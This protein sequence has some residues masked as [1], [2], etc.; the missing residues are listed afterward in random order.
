MLQ[1][2][3]EEITERSI[4]RVLILLGAPLVI[5]NLIHVANILVDTFWLGRVG[6][7]AVAAV[8]LA[9]PV[10]SI[11]AAGI[12]LVAVGTQITL[13]QRVGADEF[14]QARRLAFTG[15]ITAFVVGSVIS[16]IFAFGSDSLM[17]VLGGNGN[18]G[19]LAALYLWS[20]MLFYPIAF[21]SDTLENAFIGWGDTTA[22]LY[23]NLGIVGTN[24]I[25]DPFLILG[26]GPF[27]SFGVQGAAL[28]TG[29][30]IVVG[31]TLAIGFALGLRTTFTLD[32]ASATVEPAYVR[33]ILRVGTP[34]GGQRAVRD[35]VRVFIVGLVAIAGGTAGI[36]AFTVGTRVA[37]LAV[38]PALGFQQ[39]AQAMIS[40][41]IG[42]GRPD[43]ALKATLTGVGLVTVGLGLLGLAQW[44]IPGL[45]V[46]VLV[47]DVTPAGRALS[48]RFLRILA[49]SYWAMGATYLFLAAFNGA[50][51]TRTSFVVD[52]LKYWGVR[53]PIAL[54]AI[55]TTTTFAVFGIGFSPGLGLGIEAIFWAQAISIIVAGIGVTVY[56]AHTTQRGM[57]QRAATQAAQTIG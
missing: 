46:D 49:I 9:F 15:V 23:I 19:E 3:P 18:A 12:A 37:T 5:Q 33:E 42:A 43:R 54:A 30:G 28:A 21:A 38:V 4:P 29:A 44:L 41:N 7:T 24:V 13:A 48:I 35:I 31:F 25:L 45:I 40:Q 10:I 39:A 53:F 20:L 34:L 11:V 14:G 57:F 17:N 26:L 51:R 27:P 2:D 8:G 47:P 6:E 55:P 56:F 22:A 16:G 36:A 32:R 1:V 52:L 50:R